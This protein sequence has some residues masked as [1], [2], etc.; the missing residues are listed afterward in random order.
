MDKIRQIIIVGG[1]TAGWI[2]AG[3]VAAKYQGLPNS[4]LLNITLVESPNT[5]IVGVGEGTWPTMRGTLK[6]MGIRET[7]FIRECDA[8]F[9]QGAKFAK[10]VTGADDDAYY[11]PLVLPQGFIQG[12]TAYDWLSGDRTDSFADA[13]CA[14]GRVCEEDLAPKDITT[15][16][17]DGHL[18]YAYHLNAGKFASFIR[19]HVV[20]KLGVTHVYAD[21]TDAELDEQ[22]YVT[23]INTQQAGKIAGDL[24]VDCTG[25]RSLLLG[26]AMGVD[27]VSCTDVLFIDNALALHCDYPNAEADIASHTIST[28]QDAGWIWDIGL[29]SRRGIG[30]VYS[31]R[32]TDKANVEANLTHYVAQ[33]GANIDDIDVRH[34]PINSGYRKQFWKNNVVGVG[35]SAGF[36]EPLEASAI[37]LVEMS[38]GMIS[39]LMPT[40][41]AAMKVV[42]RRFND[43]F[44]YRW[45][46]IIDF[47]KLHYCLSKRD[48]NQFWVDNR[49]PDTIPDS[50]QE[51]LEFW[52]YQAPWDADFIHKDEVFPSASYQYVLYGMGFETEASFHGQSKRDRDFYLRQRKINQA[53]SDKLVT[54]L[55]KHRTLINKI[56]QYGMQ[57]V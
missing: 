21:M 22:G 54:T 45:A 7:D 18:N 9:K 44:D 53:R 43:V 17:Y 13:V 5:P 12:N 48:D 15:P 32:H 41:R 51:L 39:D 29:S 8:T 2:T 55:P 19:D 26:G 10:W 49:D 52:K 11:H 3:L 34:I 28:A 38:A 4:E 23:A 31:S 30:H 16:E 50:L 20:Q 27:F 40:N 46:R 6:K 36:L 1:G 42:E 25:F 57:T 47:L 14:Q 35:L 56:Y 37:V 33:L 24:F